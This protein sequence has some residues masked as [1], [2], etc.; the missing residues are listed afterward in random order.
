MNKR[1]VVVTGVGMVT[2]LG[3]N[4]P[5]T[6]K[7]LLAGLS[8]VGPIDRFDT[9]NYSTTIAAQI[10]GFNKKMG[11]TYLLLSDLIVV[12]NDE[13]ALSPVDQAILNKGLDMLLD[14]ARKMAL[15]T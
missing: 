2:A 14:E 5:D 3:N 12:F 9:T 15:L 10:K 4:A 1:R 6:W 13:T 11:G 7:G 8:G